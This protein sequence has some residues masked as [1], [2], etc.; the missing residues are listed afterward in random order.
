VTDPV[1]QT[2]PAT[3]RWIVRAVV[4]LLGAVLL[5]GIGVGAYLAA[6]EKPLPD[7]IVAATS[8]ALGALSAVLVSTKSAP[9]A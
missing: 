8:G 6:V 9:P 3:D 7:F 5:L 4:V 1:V 2:E